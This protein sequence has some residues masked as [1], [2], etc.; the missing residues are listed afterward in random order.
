MSPSEDP[1]SILKARLARGEITSEE[2]ERLRE[3]VE[4]PSASEPTPP[5]SE[6]AG[7][8]DSGFDLDTYRTDI[9]EALRKRGYLIDHADNRVLA[10]EPSS[11]TWTTIGTADGWF[12]VK[13][14][15]GTLV[16]SFLALAVLAGVFQAITHVDLQESAPAVITILGWL[17]VGITVLWAL[18]ARSRYKEFERAHEEACKEI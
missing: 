3:T 14:M 5:A 13:P 9:N 7:E 6:A 4:E 16:G 11:D 15:L 17:P 8:P 10:K 18:N 12:R 2:Y 1:I